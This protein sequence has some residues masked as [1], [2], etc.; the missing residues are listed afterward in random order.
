MEQKVCSKNRCSGKYDRSSVINPS[1]IF[2]FFKIAHSFFMFFNNCP[3]APIYVCF[4]NTKCTCFESRQCFLICLENNQEKQRPPKLIKSH[5]KKKVLQ[6]ETKTSDKENNSIFYSDKHNKS[7]DSNKAEK[8]SNI[9]NVV[10]L[11]SSAVLDF[12]SRGYSEG[13]V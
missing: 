1:I 4:N 3:C 8:E 2:D 13:T 7:N 5:L 11:S 12:R 6:N 10:D 9:K